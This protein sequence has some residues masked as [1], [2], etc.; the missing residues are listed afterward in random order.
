MLEKCEKEIPSYNVPH[1][2]QS[3]SIDM[4]R[5]Y[6]DI[7][8]TEKAREVVDA[9]WKNSDQSVTFYNSLPANLFPTCISSSQF[10]MFY[11]MR[12]LIDIASAFDMDLA[13]QYDSQLAEH[14]DT[15][16]RKGG[17]LPQ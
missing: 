10:H 3:G 9:L 5:A 12:H 15:Y 17:T 6:A 1:D 2:F 7:G 13:E 8:N 16:I 14:L 11:V 4:A